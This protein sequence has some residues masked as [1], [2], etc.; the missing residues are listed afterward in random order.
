MAEAGLTPMQVIQAATKNS[1]EALRISKEFGTLRKGKAADLIVLDKN[2]LDDI[3]NTR[4]ISSVYLDG[5]RFDREALLPR[6]K[7][8]DPT[9]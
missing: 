7:G 1:A 5:A 8:M 6:L 4:T 2:P 9:P 3:R